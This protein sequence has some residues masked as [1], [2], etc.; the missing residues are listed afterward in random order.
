MKSMRAKLK[1]ISVEAFTGCEKLKF[2]AVCKPS[3]DGDGADEDNTYAKFSPNASLEIMVTNPALLD[4][5]KPGEVYY[6]DFTQAE[7]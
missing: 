1:L 5:F 3:Y 2:N 4:T 7:K 6:V